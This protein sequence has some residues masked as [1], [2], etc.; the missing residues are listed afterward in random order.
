MK[1]HNLTLLL[2][3]A[4]SLA[5]GWPQSAAASFAKPVIE[6]AEQVAKL[7]GKK[8]SKAAM[9][10]LE[11]GYRLH[12]EA[13]LS[14]ARR[15]G[16]E[17]LEAAGRHGDEVY[18]MTREVPEAATALAVHSDTLVPL[19]RQ[20]G[21]PVLEIASRFP[22][23]VDDAVRLFP[24]E[25][26]LTRLVKLPPD[27]MKEVIKLS[28]HAK[29]AGVPSRLLAGVERTAGKILRKIDPKLVLATGLSLA[30]LEAAEAG[31]EAVRKSPDVFVEKGKEVILPIGLGAGAAVLICGF[32]VARRI[33]PR[34]RK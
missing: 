32:A 1:I 20:H 19:A 31:G 12:G 13:A 9:E 14:A 6:V 28:H 2:S 18:R 23:L 15:G 8:P 21:K 27:Q 25:G 24:A 29:E 11:Q 33:H 10:A 26:E 5:I 34:S 17:L 3:S 4:M 16:G 30:M 7:A 22:G